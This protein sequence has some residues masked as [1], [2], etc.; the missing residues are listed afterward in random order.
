VQLP[1]GIPAAVQ[2]TAFRHC[3]PLVHASPLLSRH[4]VPPA[5][6]VVFTVSAQPVVV[7][8]VHVVAHAVVLAQM[9]P[10]PQAAAAGVVQAPAVPLQ[11]LA[12]VN[13]LVVVLHAAAAHGVP[14]AQQSTLHSADTHW[15]LAVQAPPAL[16]WGTHVVPLQ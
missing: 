9:R 13:M 3:V 5:L 2:Q 10:L 15:S 4:A 6:Q 7:L 8:A 11:L 12:G 1:L 16:F 14:E